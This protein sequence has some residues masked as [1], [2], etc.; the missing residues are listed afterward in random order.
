MKALDEGLFEARVEGE[1]TIT[2]LYIYASE[3]RVVS[4][5][6]FRRSPSRRQRGT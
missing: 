2:I 1:D 5:T 4:F 3:R 6:R